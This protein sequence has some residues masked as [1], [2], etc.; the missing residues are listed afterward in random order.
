MSD[1]KLARAELVAKNAKLQAWLDRGFRLLAFV[2]MVAVF[3]TLFMILVLSQQNKQLNEINLQTNRRLIE[4]T[5]PGYKCFSDSQKRTG[6]VIVN[7]NEATKAAVICADRPGSIT[8]E[9]MN[10]CMLDHLA[11]QEGK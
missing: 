3:V 5:T 4:C 2:A 6:K 11:K 8:E 9:E 7:L 1:A 10:Q